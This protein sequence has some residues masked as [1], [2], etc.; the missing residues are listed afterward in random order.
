MLYT[1]VSLE[2]GDHRKSLNFSEPTGCGR[3]KIVYV[4]AEAKLLNDANEQL[5][6]FEGWLLAKLLVIGCALKDCMQP[7]IEFRG[8]DS[9]ELDELLRNDYAQE[10]IDGPSV[11]LG[12]FKS[13]PRKLATPVPYLQVFFVAIW[14]MSQVHDP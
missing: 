1:V 7:K 13:A 10:D 14:R 8:Q 12:D 3:S 2:A 4:S 5:A 6:S 11:V 9:L